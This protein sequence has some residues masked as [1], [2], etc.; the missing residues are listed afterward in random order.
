L[1]PVAVVPACGSVESSEQLLVSHLTPNFSV[2]RPCSRIDTALESVRK[3]R[4]LERNYLVVD[5]RSWVIHLQNFFKNQS[6]LQQAY[7]SSQSKEIVASARFSKEHEIIVT[8]SQT[9]GLELVSQSLSRVCLC[10][11]LCVGLSLSLSVYLCVSLSL[12]V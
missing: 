10:V 5:A 2:K 11:C 8:T 7:F 12:C 9:T 3:K 1:Q 4:W 6:V